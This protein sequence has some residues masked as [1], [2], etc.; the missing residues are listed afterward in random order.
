MS[1][2]A[3]PTLTLPFAIPAIPAFSIPTIPNFLPII[4][5]TLPS[6]PLD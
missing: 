6:C 5:I 3:I 4:I 1:R 2:C